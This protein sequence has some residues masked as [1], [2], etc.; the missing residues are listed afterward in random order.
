M[1]LFAAFLMLL[2]L[3]PPSPAHADIDAETQE[4]LSM[5]MV[6]LMTMTVSIST[7]TKQALS[8]APSVVSV[9]TAE[10]IR[11]TG[12]T[13]LME[14]LQSVPGIYIRVNQFGFRPLVSMRGASPKNTLIM[15]DGA[16]ERDLVWATGIFWKGLP[17]SMIERIEIIRGP[18][19]ALFGSDASAGVINVITKTAG[20]ITQSEGGVRIGSFDTQTAWLQHGTKWNGFDVGLTLEA[21]HTDGH[22]PFIARDWLNISDHANLGYDNLDLRFSIGRDHWRVQ[23]DHRQK[24]N[25]GIGI[26]GG[27][28]LDPVTHAKD[29]QTGIAWLYS[30]AAA[31]KDWGL[32]AEVRYRDLEYSSG[33]GFWEV[34]ATTLNAVRSAEQR[35]NFEASGLYTGF[36]GHAFRIGGGYVWQDLY[37]VKQATNGVPG[38]FVPE[39]LRQNSYLFVQDV[40]NLAERWE[41][42]AG[43]RYDRYTGFPGTL[44]PRLALVW[45]S[46][47]RLT[48][49]LMHGRAFRTPSFLELYAITGATNPN[50]NLV[51]EKSTTWDL[52]FG[53]R[54]TKDLNLGLSLFHYLQSNPIVDAAGQFMNVDPHRIRGIELEAIWQATNTLRI[55]GNYTQRRPDD[56]QFSRLRVPDFFSIPKRDAYLRADWTFRPKWNWNLQANWTGKRSQASNDT[57]D[58]LG[59]QAVADTTIRYYH[60]SEW[61]FAA[62]IRNLFNADAREYSGTRIPFYLPQPRRSFFAEA[63]YKF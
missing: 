18:G 44:N 58:P 24:D 8:K 63:R 23:A 20:K 60:G 9:I 17:A 46:T 32:D 3:L 36:K 27:S 43:M 49:K 25:L 42:T 51:P 57:R 11:A 16:P 15:I 41:L 4:L 34:P 29:R 61:E 47:E 28:Y 37:Y 48:T 53:Y 7:Q 45:E 40:W 6:D 55:S 39:K 38:F 35:L 12:T 14:I 22:R 19:S 33:N 5:S 1:R 50:A 59:A 13:N 10:D 52:F 56:A 62:S 31:A 2:C 26:T 54:A 30:N 21:S